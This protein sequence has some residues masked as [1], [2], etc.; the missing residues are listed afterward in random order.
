MQE[1]T[2]TEPSEAGEV[3]ILD[4][5][6]PWESVR[7]RGED[8]RKKATVAEPGQRLTPARLALLT[9]TG[10][11]GVTVSCRPRVGL[12][13]TGSELTEPGEDLGPG[14]IYETNRAVMAALTESAG[15]VPEVFPLVHDDLESTRAALNSAFDKCDVVVT[16]GG[17]SVGEMDFVKLALEETAGRLDF[18][19]VNIRPGRP[20]VFGR[21]EPGKFLFGLPGNPVSAFVTF[22][23]LVRPALL[24]WQGAAEIGLLSHPAVLGEPLANAGNRRHFMRVKVRADGRVFSG[25]M[26]ASHALSSLA[27]ADGL[28]DVPPATV[29]AAGTTVNVL[30]W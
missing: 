12:I 7:L 14:R 8:V 15:G 27:D 17:V 23:L 20:F 30:R 4:G 16:S 22:L 18:W 24:R 28:V 11:A 5:A 13:A 10:C 26:Q 19:K 2:R 29:F 1:D 6:K 3:M 21:R 25:G 9:A